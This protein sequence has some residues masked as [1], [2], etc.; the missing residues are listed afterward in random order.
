MFPFLSELLEG[1][2]D[3]KIDS[4]EIIDTRY[5]Y[6]YDGG[7]IEVQFMV[8]QH[9]LTSTMHFVYNIRPF[10]LLS[11]IILVFHL[12]LNSWVILNPN[13]RPQGAV[14]IVTKDVM[15]ERYFSPDKPRTTQASH[16][17]HIQLDH[18]DFKLTVW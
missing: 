13:F 12:V 4:Y 3:D 7:H 15:A 1:K 2:H 18:Q 11:Q 5:P 6:E 10:P 16:K 9:N 8:L 17:L 14:N